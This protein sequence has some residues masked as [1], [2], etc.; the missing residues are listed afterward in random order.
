MSNVN[1]NYQL[2]INKLDQ[3]IRKFY[4]NQL[5]RGVLYSA[6]VNIIAIS[7]GQSTRALLLLWQRNEEGDVLFFCWR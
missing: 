3:F 7:C 4:I 1:N 5:I 2:L 6:R